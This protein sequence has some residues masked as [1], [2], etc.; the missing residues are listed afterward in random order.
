MILTLLFTEADNAARR[1]SR[2]H[3]RRRLLLQRDVNNDGGDLTIELAHVT[4]VIVGT[5][6]A[7]ANGRVVR[8]RVYPGGSERTRRRQRCRG[9]CEIYLAG[10]CVG[11]GFTQDDARMGQGARRAWAM[12]V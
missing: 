12:G 2:C 6:A 11:V 5:S 8:Q 7:V 9:G 10:F 3:A 4:I 1:A